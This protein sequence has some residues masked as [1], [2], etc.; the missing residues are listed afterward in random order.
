MLVSKKS[1]LPDGSYEIMYDFDPGEVRFET[2][3]EGI[4]YDFNAGARIFIANK[5]LKGHTYEIKCFNLDTGEGIKPAVAKKDETGVLVTSERCYHIHFDISITKD[6][7][8]IFHHKFDP[9][10][11]NVHIEMM[12]TNGMGDA[13]CFMTHIEEFRKQHQCNVYITMVK[14]FVEIFEPTFKDIHFIAGERIDEH[15]KFPVNVW[16]Q[17]PQDIY[18]TY[19]YEVGYPKNNATQR[20]DLRVSGMVLNS[21]YILGVNALHEFEPKLLPSKKRA[22]KNVI[23]E[24]YVCIA[25][26]G[27]EPCKSWHNPTGWGE[28]VRYLKD[29]GLRVLCID[30]D[31]I[32][33]DEHYNDLMESGCEDFTGYLPLQDRIDLLTDAKFFIGAASGLSWLAWACGV[34][35]VMISGFSLPHSEFYTPYRVINTEVCHGCWND[36]RYPKQPYL[37][38]LCPLHQNTPRQWECSKKITAEMVLNKI[39]KLLNDIGYKVKK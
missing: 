16:E 13:I 22:S 14:R 35:V 25:L 4:K 24:P 9:K 19:Y 34:P 2:G 23:K 3:V 1:K 39:K 32:S 28:V 29:K 37:Y 27:S 12:N 7:K 11:K 21:G 18:A 20:E 10:G 15:G 26:H 6:G 8:E 36:M 5:L 38:T 30:G 17:L 31:G 33:A